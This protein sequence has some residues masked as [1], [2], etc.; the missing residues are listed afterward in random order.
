MQ[1]ES[2]EAHDSSLHCGQQHVM[3]MVTMHSSIVVLLLTSVS[4]A[5]SRVYHSSLYAAVNNYI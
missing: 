5:A 1:A 3:A 4:A 2:D